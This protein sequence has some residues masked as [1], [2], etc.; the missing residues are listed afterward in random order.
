MSEREGK[1][2]R[3]KEQIY[4]TR[5]KVEKSSVY[6]LVQRALLKTQELADA[7]I[8]QQI[9]REARWYH[10]CFALKNTTPSCQPCHLLERGARSAAGDSTRICGSA[11]SAAMFQNIVSSTDDAA[12]KFEFHAGNRSSCCYNIDIKYT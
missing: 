12:R 11:L 4:A 2:D 10:H 1:R 7:I 5:R 6:I 9:L 8:C 3:E